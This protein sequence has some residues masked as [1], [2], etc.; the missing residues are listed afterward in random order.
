MT[1]QTF[2]LAPVEAQEVMRVS[3]RVAAII[4]VQLVMA[5]L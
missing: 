3:T 2:P 5:G 1:F 4:P